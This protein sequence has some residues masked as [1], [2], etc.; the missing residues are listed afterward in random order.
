MS[1]IGGIVGGTIGMVFGGP[2]GAVIGA[3]V[4][5][6]MGAAASELNAAPQWPTSPPP[7]EMAIDLRIGIS[8]ADGVFYFG[9]VLQQLPPDAMLSVFVLSNGDVLR[10]H[11]KLSDGEGY[12][13]QSCSITNLEFNFYVPFAALENPYGPHEATLLLSVDTCSNDAWYNVGSRTYAISLPA[14]RPWNAVHYLRPL[15]RFCMTVAHADG[16]VSTQEVQSIK[17]L[18]AQEFELHSWE[19]PALRDAM[20]A[21]P[22]MDLDAD[23]GEIFRRLPGCSVVDLVNLAAMVIHADGV[24]A[25]GEVDMLRRV[26]LALAIDEQHFPGILAELN[27]VESDHWAVL[28]LQ[29]G[30]SPAEIKQAYRSLMK[31]Y[32][33]DRVASMPI[34]F[35][36]LAHRKSVEIATA[37]EALCV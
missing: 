4:G 9:M 17:H 36:E 13:M 34:E 10:T 12:F 32:H 18:F 27:M 16:V 6:G 25:P 31:Q 26:L 24:V 19:L 1:W 28:G 14:D 7:P 37:Y 30:A 33:P 5:A 20:K 22:S 35:R 15:I 21:G 8:D 29:R 23:I 3:G 2:V 11:S